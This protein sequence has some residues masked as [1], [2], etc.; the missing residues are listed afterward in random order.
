MEYK[1]VSLEKIG[2]SIDGSES[3]ADDGASTE[4]SCGRQKT[5]QFS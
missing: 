4:N 3:R 5:V 2:V 1:F